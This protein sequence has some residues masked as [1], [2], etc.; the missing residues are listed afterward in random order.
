MSGFAVS[1]RRDGAPIARRQAEA[2]VSSMAVR[3]ASGCALEVEGNLALASLGSTAAGAPRARRLVCGARHGITLLV[4]GRID[5]RAELAGDLRLC[6][7][8]SSPLSDVEL[9]TRVYET[10]GEAGLARLVGPLA[11]VV[12]EARR[13]RLLLWRDAM[14]GRGMYYHLDARRLVAASEA[15]AIAAQP[16]VGDELDESRMSALFAV[17]EPPQGT[18]FFARVRELPPGHLLRVEAHRVSLERWHQPAWTSIRYRRDADYAEHF[19]ELFDAAVQC[20][21]PAGERAALLV[22]GGLDSALLA[23]S[24]ARLAAL[25]PLAVSWTFDELESCDERHFMAPL[26][27]ALGLESRTVCG[28]DAWP[29]ADFATWPRNPSTPEDTAYRRLHQAAYQA[30]ADAGAHVMLGGVFGDQ[31]FLGSEGWWWSLVGTG[32]LGRAGVEALRDVRRRGFAGFTRYALAGPV[33]RRLVRPT[34]AAEAPRPWLV[35]RARRQA[36]S[37][38]SA[39]ARSRARRPEQAR[40]VSGALAA[41]GVAHESW[42]AVHAGVELRLPMRDQR[43][44]DFMLRIPADQLDRPGRRR[45]IVRRALRGR[46]PARIRKRQDKTSMEALFRRGLAR[47]RATVQALLDR[48]GARWSRF[49]DR[50]WLLQAPLANLDRWD[51]AHLFVLWL[52]ICCEA[53]LSRSTSASADRQIC[54]T[55][56]A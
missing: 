32:R 29:L 20:R 9:A 36:A 2:L 33:F 24:A 8:E 27:A 46:V 51:E 43:L 56:P 17:A 30:A 4:D 39:A 18:T 5:N 54:R 35:P 14:G 42:H 41:Q 53:W 49:V 37:F 31:L 26:V 10:W 23:Q 50:R 11:V 44:V 48:P 6:A 3:A 15:Y 47:E 12:H 38:E 34:A 55:V 45:P 7:A 28:D 1:F 25:P 22:S 16:G 19:S 13:D 40:A 52:A 21:L